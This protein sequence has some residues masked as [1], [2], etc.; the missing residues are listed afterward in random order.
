MQGKE[1][2]SEESNIGMGTEDWKPEQ[3]IGQQGG[4][5]NQNRIA[6]MEIGRMVAM[7]G[8][9][10]EQRATRDW[11]VVREIRKVPLSKDVSKLSKRTVWGLGQDHDVIVIDPAHAYRRKVGQKDNSEEAGRPPDPRP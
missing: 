3:G 8:F 2:R 5:S 4:K 7:P 10:Q 6:K 11:P 9:L 1:G